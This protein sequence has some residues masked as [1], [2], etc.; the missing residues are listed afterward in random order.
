[1]IYLNVKLQRIF[2]FSIYINRNHRESL[3]IG[4]T[5]DIEST[6]VREDND[7]VEVIVVQT[8][9]ENIPIRIITAYGP[10]ENA[11]KLK[12]KKCFGSS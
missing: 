8:V 5:K 10:Q 6:L 4:I 7:N 2:K 3:A 9:I 12:K 11:L 1:M